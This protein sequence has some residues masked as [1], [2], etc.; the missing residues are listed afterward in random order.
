VRTALFDQFMLALLA[1]AMEALAGYPS[2]LF[3]RIGHPAIWLGR[4]VALLDRALNRDDWGPSLRRAAGVAAAAIIASTAFVVGAIIQYALLS[5]PFGIF[6]LA[7]VSSTMLAQRSLYD[8]VAE[9]ADAL[10]K[11]SLQDGRAAVS[12]IVGRDVSSLDVSGV[13]RAAIESLAENFSDA[14]VAPALWLALFGLPGALAYKA[15]NTADSMIGHRT[16]RHE[17][18]GWAAARVDDLLNLPASRLSSILLAMAA[19]ARSPASSASAMQAIRRDARKHVSPNAG[20]PEAAAAGALKLRLGGPRFYRGVETK[21]EWL[22]DGRAEAG[23]QDIRGALKLY[24]IAIA[25]LWLG[26]TSIIMIAQLA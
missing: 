9:V 20:W 4:F 13:S 25:L 22:G 6:A 19:T 1:L 8:H 11:S 7:A 15:T 16:S 23:A 2:S 12:K 24:R 14:V 17:A 5:L 26:F 3:E 21:G 10:E 18:F